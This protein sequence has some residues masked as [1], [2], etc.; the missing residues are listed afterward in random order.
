MF[1]TAVK[2]VGN[3]ANTVPDISTAVAL[4]KLINCLCEKTDDKQLTKTSGKS[5]KNKI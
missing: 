2:Y 1:R 3:F 5:V 4:L